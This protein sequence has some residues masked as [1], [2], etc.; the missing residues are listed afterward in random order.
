MFNDE[1][2]FRRN[3]LECYQAIVNHLKSKLFWES[4]ILKNAAFPD[5]RKKNSSGS[6]S[7]ISNLTLQICKPLETV[8][9]KVFPSWSTKEEVCDKVCSEWR[10]YQMELISESCYL[11][12]ETSSSSK[13]QQISYWEKAFQ[14]CGLPGDEETDHPSFDADMF[15]N[16]LENKILSDTGSSK[17]L[18]IT[19]LS[20]LFHHLHMETVLQRMAVQYNQCFKVS[21][22]F[23][24]E[25]WC[26]SS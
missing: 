9:S 1:K 18:C 23:A 5:P 15:K 7:A 2:K 4:T 8:S 17:F 21:F 26:V 14:L 6:L 3:C 24:D 25:R 11:Q 16:S 12:E 13:H 19:S 20:K 10:V 22:C